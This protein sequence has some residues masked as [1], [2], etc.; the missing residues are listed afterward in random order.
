[1]YVYNLTLDKYHIITLLETT[2]K[3][4][5]IM[6]IYKEAMET[7]E[8][9]RTAIFSILNTSPQQLCFQGRNQFCPNSW[10][11]TLSFCIITYIVLVITLATIWY[12]QSHVHL[13]YKR[14]PGHTLKI[15]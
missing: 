15:W 8:S 10:D 9:V 11:L 5:I 7:C 3:I 1:M 4:Q 13:P 12:R 2:T 6:V 14:K